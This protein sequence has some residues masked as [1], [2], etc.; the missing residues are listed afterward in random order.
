[1]LARMNLRDFFIGLLIGVG[2]TKF[3]LISDGLLTRTA[4]PY[5]KPPLTIWFISIIP[6]V[7]IFWTLDPIATFFWFWRVHVIWGSL[8][9]VES[10]KSLVTGLAIVLLVQLVIAISEDVIRPMGLT[11][12]AQR[13]AMFSWVMIGT[14]P[15]LSILGSANL[16]VSAARLPLALL[17]VISLWTRKWFLLVSVLVALL[18]AFYFT[19]DS[20]FEI[21]VVKNAFWIRYELIV[22]KSKVVVPSQKTG[23]LVLDMVKIDNN[24]GIDEL[25]KA[26]G[27]DRPDLIGKAIK[28]SDGKYERPWLWHGYGFGSYNDYTGLVKPHNTYLLIWYELGLLSILLF[29]AVILLLLTTTGKPFWLLGTYLIYG[30]FVDDFFGLPIGL[31]AIGFHFWFISGVVKSRSKISDTD[32][33]FVPTENEEPCLDQFL[34]QSSVQ[35]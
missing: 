17:I 6:L 5:R 31:Y 2:L 16:G 25:V 33:Y 26:I 4:L 18:F 1:M 23:D 10:R 20:R 15:F 12:N 29:L 13:Y 34:Y 22:G 32:A 8:T 7:T 9:K 19:P 11:D 28:N 21:P 24:D 3:W 30:F 14:N 35:G 27:L